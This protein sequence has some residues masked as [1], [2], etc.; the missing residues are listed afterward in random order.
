MGCQVELYEKIGIPVLHVLRY[1]P[2]ERLPFKGSLSCFLGC[3]RAF[4][5]K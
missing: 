5:K 1:I 4:S 3:I 2:K